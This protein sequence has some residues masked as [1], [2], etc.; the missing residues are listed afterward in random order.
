MPLT[1][2]ASREAVYGMP[3]DEWKA[4]HQKDA[5]PAQIA[6]LEKSHKH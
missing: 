5:S 2:D 4:K 6:A 3:Y 1:K